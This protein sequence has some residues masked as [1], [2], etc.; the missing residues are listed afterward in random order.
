MQRFVLNNP[1]V[2]KF[3]YLTHLSVSILVG[4]GAW[5]IIHCD[6]DTHPQKPTPKKIEAYKPL[7][8]V[9]IV[10][11]TVEITPKNYGKVFLG[12]QYLPHEH[13]VHITYAKPASNH[14]FITKYCERINA[15]NNEIK[16]H[17]IEHARKAYLT[18]NTNQYDAIT[19]VKIAIMN[20]IMAPAAEI[21][22]AADTRHKTGRP[23]Q[24][25][26][27]TIKIADSLIYNT[28]AK[29]HPINGQINFNNQQI[30]DII[31]EHATNRYFYDINRGLY[32]STLRHELRRKN[33]YVKTPMNE[34]S[35]P[36]I[37]GVFLPQCGIW[38]PLW[39][40]DAACGS[41]NLWHAASPAAKRKLI[42]RIDSL[43][44]KLIAEKPGMFL[45]NIKTY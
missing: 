21:I 25:T 31:L 34:L 37:Q 35:N 17:E 45:G 7:P 10:Y 3:K 23:S 13:T 44:D 38:A 6:T 1:I 30:A 22:C 41:V 9:K 18:K 27:R 26:H 43:V 2:M 24:S 40:F 4:I 42:E 20:E 29:H 14:A 8:P 16:A 32:I 36:T 19:R 15:S 28:I 5:A 11:D 39:Q 12:G 33:K